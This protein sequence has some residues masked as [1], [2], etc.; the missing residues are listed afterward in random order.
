M[1]GINSFTETVNQLIEQV[2]IALENVVQLNKSITTQ[3][4]TVTISVDLMDPITGDTSTATYS[5]PSYNTVINKVNAL[6]QTMD[7]FVKGEGLVLLND[8]TYRK[9]TTQPVAISP[10]DI[11]NIAPPTKFKTRDNWF[12]ESMMSPQ[13]IV[14]FNLK[15]KID[16]RSDRVMVKRVIFDNSSEEET[17]WFL[18]NFLN[19][20]RTYYETIQFLNINGKKYWED[21]EMV[22]VPLSPEPY[23]GYFVIKD[24]RT[25]EGK[26]WFYF[27]T[28]NYGET[29]DTVIVK[30]YQLAIGDHL[31]YGNS[32]WVI[33][34]IQ[35]NEKRVQ[36]V[37][38]IG[39]DHP[40]INN[41][42]EIYTAPFTTKTLDIPIGYNE[43]NVVFFKAVNEDFN[44]LADTWGHGV[45]FWTSTLTAEDNNSIT[46]EDYYFDYVADFGKQLEGQAKERFIPAFFGEIPDAPVL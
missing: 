3:D 4:D 37:P 26:E 36:L 32:I 14:T 28:M 39:M 35:I 30:N 2:N 1:S 38:H 43:C 11:T 34:D 22:D 33:S 6:Y 46:L 15:N 7:T 25:I 41:S 42:F 20:E 19:I 16:D 45:A 9:V 13:L 21:Q 8:G 18:D 44:I 27:D 40:T 31:R 29:S 24:K 5:I 10:D 12:F 23:M 17:Q